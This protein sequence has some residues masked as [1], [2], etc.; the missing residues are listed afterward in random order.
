MG[1]II[2][3]EGDLLVREQLVIERE[4]EQ[5]RQRQQEE[6]GYIPLVPEGPLRPISWWQERGKGGGSSDEDSSSSSSDYDS[7]EELA[8]GSAFGNRFAR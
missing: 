3:T 6:E 5:Q 4:R 7:G 8:V 1:P 2:D